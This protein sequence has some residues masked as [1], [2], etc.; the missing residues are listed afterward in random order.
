V[1]RAASFDPSFVDPFSFRLAASTGCLT[2]AQAIFALDAADRIGRQLGGWL[3]S[4]G[5]A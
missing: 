1:V 3:R 4:L 2:E 5:P